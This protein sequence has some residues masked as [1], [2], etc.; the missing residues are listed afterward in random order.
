MR[1]R[2][3]SPRVVHLE[4]VG[5]VSLVSRIEGEFLTLALE[6]GLAEAIAET[7]RDIDRARAALPADAADSRY[8]KRLEDQR[9][10][11]RSPTLRTIAALVVAMCVKDPDLTPRIRKAFARLVDAH[12]DLIWLYPQLP[13]DPGP[14]ALRRAG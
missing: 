6:I 12:Q 1:H 5:G 13:A 10:S 7:L 4:P 8:R 3:I 14:Q 9:A 2:G 11:L